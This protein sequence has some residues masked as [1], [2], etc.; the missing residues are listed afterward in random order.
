MGKYFYR[1][2]GEKEF[3]TYTNEEIEKYM[4]C[5]SAE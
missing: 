2:V 1:Y 5:S 3:I 4:V